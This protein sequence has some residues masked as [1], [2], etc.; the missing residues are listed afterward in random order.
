[1]PHEAGQRRMKLVVLRGGD[2]GPAGV[3]GGSTRSR[4]ALALSGNGRHWAL[5]NVSP[6]VAFQLEADPRLR[7]HAG[8][9]DAQVRSV[10]LTDAQVDHVAGLLGLRDGPPIDLYATPAV[11]EDLTGAMPV[12]PVLQHYCGVQWRVIPVA[13]ECRRASFRVDGL[14][15]IDFT[16]VASEQEVAPYSSHRGSPQAGDT[17][18]LAVHDVASG[19]RLFCAKGL[20]H[21]GALEFEWMDEAD[22]VLLGAGETASQ[23]VEANHPALQEVLE[24]LSGLRAKRKL[25]L[26]PPDLSPGARSGRALRRDLE[27]RGIELAFDGMEIDL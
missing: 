12:L 15:D 10:V 19:Q 13:G 11:F 8:L 1:M 27:Q 14:H 3:G 6:T 2:S 9:R 17:I 5:L 20:A 16:A 24:R 26:A 23:E 25:L 4:G 18:V 22:C 21:L 7:A